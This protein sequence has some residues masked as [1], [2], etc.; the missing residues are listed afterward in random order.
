MRIAFAPVRDPLSARP[1]AASPP[2]RP[3]SRAGGPASS[4]ATTTVRGPSGSGRSASSRTTDSPRPI[5]PLDTRVV[6]SGST[7]DTGSGISGLVELEVQVH[8]AAGEPGGVEAS[9]DGAAR[10]AKLAASPKRRDLVG[11]LVGAGAAQA[12]RPVGGD[13]TRGTPAWAASSTAGCRLAARYPRWSPP[14]PGGAMPLASPRARKAR[15]ALVDPGVQPDPRRRRPARRT[16]A[17]CASPGRAPRRSARARRARST[18]QVASSV[19][20]RHG[21][22]SCRR[23]STSA[24]RRRQCSSRSGEAASSSSAAG[25]TPGGARSARRRPGAAG[26]PPRRR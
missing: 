25:S 2:A 10:S 7:S 22:R 16:A 23:A 1:A 6:A 14:R 4:P 8:R 21:R 5:A 11:G 20:A 18:S 12:G 3:A 13:A 15:G 19:E 26:R 24:I 9:G 17:R